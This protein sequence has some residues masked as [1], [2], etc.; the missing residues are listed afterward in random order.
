M[1]LPI[2]IPFAIKGAIV[3]AKFIASKHAAVTAA[4]AVAVGVK[5]YGA[6]TTVTTIA[7]GLTIVGAGI[8]TVERFNMG[9][10]ALRLF[11][12]GDH[13]GA[14]RQLTKIAQSCV[15]IGGFDFV[16]DVRSWS[17]AGGS[18]LSPEFGRLISDLRQITEE[19]SLTSRTLS[20]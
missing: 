20:T 13:L 6:A 1:P 18:I 4:K 12:A 3:A 10:Q 17:A 15:Q 8:W 9:K 19:A 5:T 16:E 2:F 14:A 7:G 11:D